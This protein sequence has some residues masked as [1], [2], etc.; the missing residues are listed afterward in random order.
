MSIGIY[1]W[2][3]CD[4]YIGRGN[5][6][7]PACPSGSGAPSPNEVPGFDFDSWFDHGKYAL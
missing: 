1:E 7:D 4:I 6:R 2:I 3:G 5:T